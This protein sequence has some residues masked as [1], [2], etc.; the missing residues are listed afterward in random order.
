VVRSFLKKRPY[1]NHLNR[2]PYILFW[3]IAGC[4]VS[5][6]GYGQMCH[7][8]TSLAEGR[9]AVLLEG[10]Y[11]LKSVSDSMLMC[12][13]TLLG[14]PLPTTLI[15]ALQPGAA[16]TIQRVAHYLLPYWSSL[17]VDVHS[18]EKNTKQKG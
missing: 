10:G 6:E 18:E 14:D 9:V 16:V 15:G 4:K 11:N 3:E 1:V 13:N 8:L 7:M 12:A 17:D 2:A 5:P